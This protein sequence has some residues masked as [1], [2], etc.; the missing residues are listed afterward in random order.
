MDKYQSSLVT[1]GASTKMAYIWSPT[2]KFKLWRKLWLELARGQHK[3]GLPVSEKQVQALEDAIDKP[4]CEI[5]AARLESE[6]HHDVM[7]HIKLF[8]DQAPISKGI[9]H[10]GATSQFVV[11]NADSMCV[12]E[13]LSHILCSLKSLIIKIGEFAVSNKDVV[14]LGL[15]HFQPAQPTTV[16]KR[17]SVWA[18]D[19]YLTYEYLKDKQAKLKARGIKGATGTQASFLELFD[20]DHDK[21]DELDHMICS[22]IGFDNTYMVTGQVYPRID[23]AIL[24]SLLTAVGAGC[25]KIATD[26]RLLAGK[27]ELAEGFGANQVGSSAMPYKRN[28]LYCERVCGLAKLMPGLATSAMATAS[29]QWLE[30]SLDDSSIRRIVLPESHLAIDAILCTMHK[31]FDSLVVNKEE[32]SANL[33]QERAL[34]MTETILMIAVKHGI[35]RQ[36]FHEKIR[37]CTLEH[38]GGELLDK[39]YESPELGDLNLKDRFKHGISMTGRAAEQTEKFYESIVRPLQAE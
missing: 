36:Q 30:R 20:G 34:L 16:G 11:D 37:Q 31:I 22:S 25:Q 4:W 26:I 38:N 6:L 24:I 19:L 17:A 35:D 27:K 7:T 33:K 9:I 5:K 3:L 21:V 29:E 15:T 32:I 23:D 39:L 2:N 1:R 10:L 18:Y 8:G 14:T 13:S 28:P 12:K